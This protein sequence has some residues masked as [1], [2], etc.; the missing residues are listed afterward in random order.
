MPP[1]KG[2]DKGKGKG[3]VQQQVL[4][5]RRRARSPAGPCPHQADPLSGASPFQLQ[6]DLVPAVLVPSVVPKP[7]ISAASNAAKWDR[8]CSRWLSNPILAFARGGH[9]EDR[10]LLMSGTHHAAMLDLL[11]RAL[12]RRAL[13]TNDRLWKLRDR[14]LSTACARNTRRIVR[15]ALGDQGQ[16]PTTWSLRLVV[17]R[18][19]HLGVCR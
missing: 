10:V 18:S 1:P 5:G 19:R 3:E 16:S 15:V 4:P 9:A 14:L 8:R 7:T 13:S 17:D 6:P 2:K 12:G 11:G